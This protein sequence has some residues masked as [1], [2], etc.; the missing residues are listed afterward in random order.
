MSV[1][2]I[3]HKYIREHPSVQ[4]C[5]ER[6][7]INYSALAREICEAAKINSFDAVLVACRRYYQKKRAHTSREQRI[8]TLM[9]KA[10]VRVR[11]KIA[12]A[13]IE[14]N[15]GLDKALE[16]Q[17]QIKKEK[18]DFNLIEGEDAFTIITNV[19]YLPLIKKAFSTGVIKSSAGLAQITMIFGETLEMTPGVLSFIYRIFSEYDINIREEMSCWKD[20]MV[21]VDEKDVARVINMLN[22]D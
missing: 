2:R 7:L 3:T 6:G 15:R 13:T 16:I 20:V 14:K 1:S 10:K 4:D 8:I 21:V 17:N 11:N 9:K 19:E 5:L 18:G 22:F 12:V